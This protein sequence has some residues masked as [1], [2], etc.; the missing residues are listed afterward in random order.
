MAEKQKAQEIKVSFPEQLKA[1]VYSNL[2]V[3]KHTREEFILDFLMVSPPEGAVSARVIM[4][5]GH[6]KRTIIALQENVK[7]YE[8]V[9]SKIQE[10]KEPTSKKGL[11]FLSS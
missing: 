3:V 7:K 2:M 10:A 5:P 4:S 9:F 6:M 8:E 1:G 11:G